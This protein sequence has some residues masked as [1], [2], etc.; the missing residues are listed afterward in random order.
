MGGQQ[1]RELGIED[2]GL[3]VAVGVEQADAAVAV[4]QGRS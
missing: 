3:P 2:D 1:R 4:L